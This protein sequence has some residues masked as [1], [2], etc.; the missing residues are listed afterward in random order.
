MEGDEGGGSEGF[1]AGDGAEEGVGG[2]R[3]EEEEDEAEADAIWR[4]K[5]GRAAAV[6]DAREVRRWVAR[7]NADMVCVLLAG[8]RRL[9]S[10]V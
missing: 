7:K 5:A 8:L 9:D 4:E 2:E 6:E 10:E 3:V 1:R